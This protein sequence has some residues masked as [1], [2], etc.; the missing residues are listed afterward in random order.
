MIEILKNK[1]TPESILTS[2]FGVEREGLRVTKQ[3]KLA[4]TPH[5]PIFGDKLKNPY[6]TTDFSES[7]IELVT[8][9]FFSVD[10]T[11]D[12][13]EALTDI[14]IGEIGTNNELFWPYSM[15]CHI[16]D[17]KQIPIATYQ[18]EEG[19]EPRQYRERLMAKYGG[20][21]QLISGIHYNF[22]FSDDFLITIWQELGSRE[23]FKAFKDRIYLKVL[24][25]Y[26]RYRW[27]LIYLMGCTPGL[28]N[29]YIEECLQCMG[30]C[31]NETFLSPGGTSARNGNCSGYKNE[32]DLYPDYRSIE[33]YI[34]SINAFVER[35]DIS[36]AKELY[37]QIRL[38]PR[39]YRNTLDSLA[40]DGVQYL[41]IR[42]IDL[43]VF[44]KC[45][46]A[47]IDLEFLNVFMLFLLLEGEEF[48][49]TWQQEALINEVTVA[50]RGL[51]PDLELLDHRHWTLK[52]AWA[53]D[54]LEKVAEINKYLNLEQDQCIKE[55]QSRV[56]QPETT[57]AYRLKLLM[58]ENGC[59]DA[60]LKIAK[61]Y[62]RQS[63]A[64]HYR[65]KGFENWEMSTQVLIK[66]ALT[67]GIKV[68]PMDAAD[69]I[70]RLEKNGRREYVKQATKTSV[71][72]YITPL[73]ME[74]KVVTKKI[75]QEN[76]LPV[77]NGEEFFSFVEAKKKLIKYVGRNVVIKPKSTNFGL[78]ISIFDQGGTLD[79]LLKGARIAFEQDNTI[80]IEDY[81]PG[82]EYR[83]LTMGDEVV[84][85]LHRRPANVVGD[86]V[87]SIQQLIDKKNQ[88]PYRGDGQTSP[89]KK[90][91][92][93]DQSLMYL[94]KQ[95]LTSQSIP[96]SNE[97]IFL[98]GNSNIS[99]GGD[100]IDFTQ[101][102]HPYFSEIAL[103]AVRAFGAKFCGIDIIL[104]DYCNP[105]SSFG[106][107]ELNFN[108]MIVMHAYP[109][110]GQELRLGYN[111]LKTIG[112]VE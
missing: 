66:E 73:L 23:S 5:P 7:Q 108:P 16:P 96:K 13:L 3:G 86:G 107:I 28:H 25:N 75:L 92:L 14:V 12:F 1:M 19:K 99:T 72:N 87:S 9:V 10:E 97:M 94:N 18:G 61:D 71:D 20:K 90:I 91:V 63:D 58:Q 74:N 67:R 30:D 79:E 22:S 55:M 44:D 24:R 100:S 93:D 40:R 17:D 57:Y 106:I 11:Y 49:D 27:L 111:I 82:L 38:K 39:D 26:L 88:H 43:N 31:G 69:N 53:E 37:A 8:P 60:N 105:D 34:K 77:P 54:I 101:K 84:A 81:L 59:L 95:G 21:R 104:E 65:L 102:M 56:R 51:E 85:V 15:P 83:F 80:L 98:R 76:G 29:S 109:F 46:I 32:I 35:G 36:E 112:L 48:F 6:I 4:M 110:E 103:K 50:E 42:T 89:L 62:K 64:D 47:K 41:E 78:G 70:V 33:S 52:T 45:G 2:G 68:I